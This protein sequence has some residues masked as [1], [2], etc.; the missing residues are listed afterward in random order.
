MQKLSM[1]AGFWFFCIAI[2]AGCASIS[3]MQQMDQFNKAASSYEKALRWGDW[4]AAGSLVETEDRG[5]DY[6]A[7]EELKQIKVTS[8]EVN[9]LV[10]SKNPLQV[11]Q[12]V[13]IQYYHM[14]RMVEKT[15][16]DKQVWAYRGE[17]G[18]RLVS[19]LPPF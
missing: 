5:M 12:T 17:G 11:K 14:H 10:M 8:Y 15:L 9:E 13:E 1:T 3:E 16:I 7:I 2:L 19:G 6:Q 18:W 4:A